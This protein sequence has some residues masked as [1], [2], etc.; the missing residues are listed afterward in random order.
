MKLSIVIPCYNEEKNI[1]LLAKKIRELNF[2]SSKFQFVFVNN[3]STDNSSIV[4]DQELKGIDCC[5]VVEVKVNQGYGFGILA[6]LK[7]ATGDF[8]GWTHADMQTDLNDISKAY[9]II[10]ESNFL[11][12]IFVKGDRR[13]RPLFDQVFTTG[14]SLFETVLLK[15]RLFDINAQPNVFHRSFYNKWD[16]PPWDFSLDLFVLYMAKK[17][18][19]VIKRF[20]VLF[21]ERIHGTSSWNNS[22]S[23]KWRF[24]KRTVKF[25]FELK[26][27]LK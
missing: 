16:N 9:G 18:G 15:T 12:D 17:E 10:E 13:G 7:N 5:K 6:G 23:G 2:D 27:R 14:M 1:P 19:L 26:K 3:G 21:L 22:L 4:F 25:S 11:T 8:L 20:N 24:I